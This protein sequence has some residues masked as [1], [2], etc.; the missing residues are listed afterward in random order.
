M[1]SQEPKRILY[2]IGSLQRGGAERHLAYILPRLDRKRFEPEIFTTGFPGSLA[3][4]LQAANVPVIA[5]WWP[6]ENSDTPPALRVL[7][8]LIMGTQLFTHIVRRKPA[9][10]HFF[11]PRSY[12]FGAPIALLARVRHTVM[13]RRSL[14]VYQQYDPS[15]A[16]IEA[17]LHRRMSFVLANSRAVLRQLIEEEGVAK[18][19]AALIYNGIDTDPFHG[20]FDRDAARRQLDI[21]EGAT[22]LVTVANL[23][24]YKGHHDLI[25]ALGAL[26]GSLPKD[27]RL[28]VV[29]RDDGIEEDLRG[30]AARHGAADNVLFLG[31]R[32]D[33][34]DLLRLSDIAVLASEQEGFSNAILESM[35]AGLPVI[36]TNVG[37]NPE[38]VVDGE[39]GIL[40]S[41]RAPDQLAR[42]IET[43]VADPER[44]KVMGQAGFRRLNE[45]FTVEHCVAEY[46]A[47]YARL[48]DVADAKPAEKT[49]EEGAWC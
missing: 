32:A 37:G 1:T 2:V 19:R 49:V 11:L 44:R 34:P 13:S 4:S 16:R 10:T 28:L 17:W 33:V 24:P 3:V 30:L 23:I 8:W 12:V 40:V 15:I 14:N 5:P 31:V 45:Q 48:L 41:P 7:R 26:R 20:D 27:W 21:P 43:L 35:A 42:A 22:V 25:N 46:E 9:I 18:D 38:A 6:M 47:F 39:T 36:A 29:G